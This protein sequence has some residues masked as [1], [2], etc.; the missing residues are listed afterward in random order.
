MAVDKMTRDNLTR[1]QRAALYIHKLWKSTGDGAP[2][3]GEELPHKPV[4]AKGDHEKA[5]RK[6]PDHP[7]DQPLLANLVSCKM[8]QCFRVFINVA[9]PLGAVTEV[10]LY[11][12][13]SQGVCYILRRC[14]RH[15]T[16]GL[17]G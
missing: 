9:L 11:T 13:I 15:T 16:D 17:H 1:L 14:F 5:Y 8:H 4:W 7:E 10:W 6:W 2:V 12:R 3:P